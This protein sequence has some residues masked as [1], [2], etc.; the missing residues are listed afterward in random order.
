MIGS[1]DESAEF[2]EPLLLISFQ[3]K[4]PFCKFGHGKRGK[5]ASP[6]YFAQTKQT[7]IKPAFKRNALFSEVMMIREQVFDFLFGRKI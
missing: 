2:K 4:A 1:K 7:Y 6:D 5:N 3:T